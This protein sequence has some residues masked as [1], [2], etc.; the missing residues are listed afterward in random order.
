MGPTTA[1][2]LQTAA[3]A[4]CR[5]GGGDVSACV[6]TATIE[7][8]RFTRQFQL[9][10]GECTTPWES[11]SASMKR[12]GVTGPKKDPQHTEA[13]GEGGLIEGLP[14][15][16]GQLGRDERERGNG[17]SEAAEVACLLHLVGQRRCQ[18]F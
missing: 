9:L 11:R 5:F 7:D 17:R 16:A 4:S 1:A 6:L 3:P 2:C 8:E 12:P 10:G 18:M 13:N 15:I 14:A